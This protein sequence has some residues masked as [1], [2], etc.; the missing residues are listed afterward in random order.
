VDEAIR[1]LTSQH[2]I[3]RQHAVCVLGE[4]SLGAAVA[5]RILPL[6]CQIVTRDADAT[7]RRLAIL[8]LLFWQKDSSRYANVVS[9]ALDDPAEEVR[10]AATYWLHEQD[11]DRPT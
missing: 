1:G 3:I 4:R 9:E 5:R 11:A 6:L 8:S 10:E 2:V 7:V